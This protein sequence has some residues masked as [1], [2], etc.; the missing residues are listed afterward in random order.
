MARPFNLT[1]Q[2]NVQ[3]PAGIR[4]VVQRLRRELS[5]IKADLKVDISPAAARNA[6]RLNQQIKQLQ[7]SLSSAASEA[8]KLSSSIESTVSSLGKL[9]GTAAKTTSS[10][11]NVAGAS[12]DMGR[13]LG[14]ARTEMEEFGRVSGLALR[15]F[16]GFTVAST[17]VFGFV[18]A[19]SEG[20]SAAVSFER[21]LVKIAQVTGQSVSQLQGL[22]AE[23]TRVSTQFGVSS[24]DLIEVARTLNQAGLSADD[25]RIA[26]EALGKS[27]LAPTFTDIRNTTE[28]AIASFR[29][30]G[31]SASELE[32]V[33]GSINAV[34]GNFAV[35]ADDIISV[36]RRT[37]GV[38]KA[39]SGDIGSPATQLNELAAIFTSVR[40]TTRE[41]AESI[42]TGL[43]TILTRIQRPRTI[44]FLKNF[45]IELQNSQGQFIG[46]FNAFQKLSEGLSDLDPRDVRFSQIVEE[47]G[48]FRQVGKLIPA[49]QQFSTAQEA[50]AVAQQGS[51]SIARDAAIAQQA[52][53]VQI[54]RVREEF[55]ALIR[56]FTESDTFRNIAGGALELASA[57]ISVADAVKPVLPFLTIIGAVRGFGL[58]RQ[59]G[60][61]FF[62]GIRAGG[63]AG[64]LGAGL[65]GAATGSTGAASQA[66]SQALTNAINGLLGV[67]KTNT[68]A[69]SANTNALNRLASRVGLGAGVRRFN[70]GGLVP[71]TGNTDTVPAML[72]PGEF[73]IRKS[74][75]QKYGASTLAGINNPIRRNRG[76]RLPENTLFGNEAVR[77]FGGIGVSR[78]QGGAKN[79]LQVG[80]AFL[81]PTGIDSDIKA[82]I[83]FNDIAKSSKLAP[84]VKQGLK[85]ALG[86]GSTKIPGLGFLSSGNI[87]LDIISGSLPKKIET[88]FERGLGDKVEGF[89]TGF[90][91]N[92]MGSIRGNIRPDFLKNFNWEQISGNVFEAMV[93]A[94]LDPFEAIKGRPNA[95]FDFPK[96]LGQIAKK[97][98]DTRLAGIPVDTKRTF[99][100]DAIGSIINKAKTIALQF[101]AGSL[102]SALGGKDPTGQLT[103]LT[104]FTDKKTGAD[105][106]EFFGTNNPFR[107]GGN[108]RG[109]R[110]AGPLRNFNAGGRIPRA[111]G[112]SIP[113][114]LTPGEF[115]MSRDATKNIGAGTLRALNKGT[116]QGF[117]KGG[118]VYGFNNGGN[119]GTPINIGGTSGTSLL[120]RALTGEIERSRAGLTN[121]N[122]AVT[123]SRLALVASAQIQQ[124]QL[125]A[126]QQFV[127]S[128]ISASQRL[129]QIGGVPATGF[130]T[131]QQ[132]IAG[133]GPKRSIGQRLKRFSGRISSTNA[134][135][136]AS[137]LPSLLP[138]EGAFG[139]ASSVATQ[140]VF[141]GLTAA[142]LNLAGPQAVLVGLGVAVLE[143][144]NQM[145]QLSIATAE[146]GRQIA[147]GKSEIALEDFSK[148]LITAS[149]LAATTQ[150]ELNANFN[151]SANRALGF[152]DKGL[153]NLGIAFGTDFDS[154]AADAILPAFA[155][156]SLAGRDVRQF[157]SQEAL[158]EARKILRVQARKVAPTETLG[159]ALDA[160]VDDA[161]EAGVVTST[162]N[163]DRLIRPQFALPVGLGQN[164]F[165]EEVLTRAESRSQRGI[166]TGPRENTREES[167]QL[168]LLALARSSAGFIGEDQANQLQ[169]INQLESLRA[170]GVGVGGRAFEEIQRQVLRERAGTGTLSNTQDEAER[171]A[172]KIAVRL[173]NEFNERRNL[174][175]SREAELLASNVIRQK[176]AQAASEAT[177]KQI[178]TLASRLK[179]VA[180]VTK[181]VSV[182]FAESTRIERAR[183]KAFE[184]QFEVAVQKNPI[185]KIL[186][187]PR[188]FTQDQIN[189]SIQ[190]LSDAFSVGGPNTFSQIGELVKVQEFV[191]RQLKE[192]TGTQGSSTV[193]L[194]KIRAVTS[195]RIQSL[196]QGLNTNLAQIFSGAADFT[197]VSRELPAIIAKE[198]QDQP[199][200]G[201]QPVETRIADA[202]R[203]RFGEG[204]INEDLI[205]LIAARSAELR[206]GRTDTGVRS[207]LEEG[208]IDELIEGVFAQQL[209]ASSEIAKVLEGGVQEFVKATNDRIKLE[210]RVNALQL[211]ALQRTSRFQGLRTQFRGDTDSPAD[212]GRAVERAQIEGL[213]GGRV[214]SPAEILRQFNQNQEESNSRQQDLLSTVLDQTAAKEASD[215]LKEIGVESNNF[216]A[217]LKLM[218]SSSA[219]I[220]KIESDRAKIEKSA[221]G[222][223]GIIEDVLTGNTDQA[224]DFLRGAEL[225]AAGATFGESAE[226]NKLILDAIKLFQTQPTTGAGRAAEAQAFGPVIENIINPIINSA[227]NLDET[228]RSGL[229]LSVGQASEA[230]KGLNGSLNTVQGRSEQASQALRQLLRA[231][232]Q[233]LA[234]IAASIQE[235]LIVPLRQAINNINRAGVIG[236]GTNLVNPPLRPGAQ[237]D[238]LIPQP[239]VRALTQ[240]GE[241]L[242]G[243]AL[244]E[245]PQAVET[246]ATTINS[247]IDRF[248]E[249]INSISDKQI[250]LRISPDSAVRLVG[251]GA[252]GQ[253]VA[254]GLVPTITRIVTDRITEIFRPNPGA[255]E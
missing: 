156:T 191:N 224:L 167:F 121:F 206:S 24:A 86:A 109:L 196:E 88:E 46:A 124:R 247:A 41:S 92:F 240:L 44:D 15:R 171:R 158:D 59:F 17:A 184:G 238:P 140:G 245:L 219:E 246:A 23:V 134:L 159:K 12:S 218:S 132:L 77:T 164:D 151:A 122:R 33:L 197:K 106:R 107:S 243:D 79:R 42:A 4:P 27:S 123:D 174:L 251:E 89:A 69:L 149:E 72:T 227:S 215:R 35:E 237:A 175:L 130:V 232:D 190:T 93:N 236:S 148:G 100:P 120:D 48:G 56:S 75:V 40:A 229:L 131:E 116:F 105:K 67:Q 38:F 165:I 214:I 94:S 220:A 80:G 170:R 71:G 82:N 233:D 200:A 87:Q 110:G 222:F 43:R 176:Q 39:A 115:V 135:L 150:A 193:E 223:R 166:L 141:G 73:V 14:T 137:F 66:T 189:T 242:G 65:A 213:L 168:S 112:D 97:F 55:D 182:N 153:R 49:I 68:T 201:G 21:E 117:N 52:L 172:A 186:E 129:N 181:V 178:D 210:Q 195:D 145:Q 250:E 127:T 36:I 212:R 138:Q 234:N 249:G 83:P 248:N 202:I 155:G 81:R 51:G 126:Q 96:G 208:K 26:L 22:S 252:F 239:A 98:G 64:G 53:A 45:N 136:A 10:M 32:G 7:G 108:L 235:K 217:A 85:Q 5:G 179:T 128:S 254:Q 161:L 187:N 154:D 19:V 101:A 192:R 62:G 244:S 90:A 180:E 125:S 1:A 31:I 103:A 205:K 163:L 183:L 253:V 146:Q 157:Q 28:G 74:S 185:S 204:S 20:V 225:L 25:T 162:A 11:K 147:A 173:V 111:G 139:A 37:G 9:Q 216:I 198:L 143:L 221:Q 70:S 230:F 78:G 57:L 99:N 231:Q 228:V 61:G 113:A 142:T 16:A 207:L 160:L 199:T 133:G 152:M 50:L 54:I 102:Q 188:A 76:S 3:G 119:Q 63:G 29:Q 95:P 203:D 169:L 241:V 60:S 209:K 118:L 18:R 114:L 194:R 211:S 177:Q 47:I 8:A 58:A 6:S 144:T 255:T 30:F 91:K 2:L 104:T 13:Q 34:A 226:T 84:K